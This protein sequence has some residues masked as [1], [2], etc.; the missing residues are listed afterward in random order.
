MP[1]SKV[2]MPK[3][4]KAKC[5][6]IIHAATATAAASA[7]APIPVA[8]TIPITAAQ[9][10]MIVA[11]GN[12]FGVTITESVG[13]SI[14]SCGIAQSVGRTI[15]SSILKS[16]PVINVTIAPVANAT[17]A[18]VITELLGWIIADDFYRL[19]IGEEPQNIT[20]GLEGLK[21]LFGNNILSGS[22]KK[23]ISKND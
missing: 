17:I 11:L 4:L 23:K 2:D 13:K 21:E 7:A 19:S 9:V 3:D 16:I 12:V 10:T 8:D 5:N 14:A 15:S 18:S 1:K 22:K 6:V 20:E